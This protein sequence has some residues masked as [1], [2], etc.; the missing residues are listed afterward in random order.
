M[1]AEPVVRVVGASVRY[2]A[3]RALQG[4]SIEAARGGVTA[5][6]GTNGAG[7][8]T[9]LR[10]VT[11]LVGLSSGRIEGPGGRDITKMA[12]HR[13]LKELGIALVPE[14]RGLFY[15]MSVEENLSFGS[16]VGQHRRNGGGVDKREEI[17]DLFPVLRDR[18]RQLAGSLSGGEQQMLSICRALLSEPAVLLLDEPSM[19]LAPLVIETVFKNLARYQGDQNLSVILV[20]QNTE[21]ALE[22]ADYVYLMEQGVIAV[23]GTPSEI[24][25]NPR[26]REI[27][28]GIE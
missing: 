27:F 5:V 24:A 12:P 19:G 26:L 13:R 16:K 1:K 4:V 18:M 23:E 2:G 6:V 28:L 22:L 8:S 17:L 10:A 11:G 21:I 20:E 25:A 14:G 7:K 3:I 15:R 9:L